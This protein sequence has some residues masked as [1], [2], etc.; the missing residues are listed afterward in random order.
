[1]RDDMKSHRVAAVV[2]S[3]RQREIFVQS[4]EKESEVTFAFSRHASPLFFP[5]SFFCAAPQLT[6]RLEEAIFTCV[7]VSF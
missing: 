6:E 2:E 3:M 1:M 7:P 4:R 5:S